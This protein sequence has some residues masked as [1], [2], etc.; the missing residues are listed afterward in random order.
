MRSCLITLEG[1]VYPG[2]TPALIVHW[3]MRSSYLLPTTHCCGQAAGRRLGG[4][5]VSSTHHRNPSRLTS[6]CWHLMLVLLCILRRN[7]QPAENPRQS[8]VPATHSSSVYWRSSV[9]HPAGFAVRTYC[10][11]HKL[12]RYLVYSFGYLNRHKKV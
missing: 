8:E 4:L 12:K 7:L 10:N 1:K 5:C 11:S 6:D 3:T 9:L 2:S